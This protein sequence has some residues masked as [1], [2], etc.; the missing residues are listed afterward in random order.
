MN[1]SLGVIFLASGQALIVRLRLPSLYISLCKAGNRISSCQTDG[2]G[3][4]QQKISPWGGLRIFW[5]HS[6]G[7]M[8][9]SLC[10][11]TSPQDCLSYSQWCHHCKLR[12]CHAFIRQ[13]FK[14]SQ[15]NKP[16]SWWPHTSCFLISSKGVA[17]KPCTVSFQ[18]QGVIPSCATWFRRQL[19]V[20]RLFCLDIKLK[21][22]SRATSFQK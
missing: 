11:G 10:Q 20:S 13:S 18:T 19:V 14:I 2:G 5:Y 17:Q 4:T 9:E 16:Y 8:R 22:S 21:D 3:K 6:N 7:V 1:L 15:M 12:Q